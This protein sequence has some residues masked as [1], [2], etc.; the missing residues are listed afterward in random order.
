[1]VQVVQEQLN[2]LLSLP[3]KAIRSFYI[4]G[5]EVFLAMVLLD[6]SYT[7]KEEVCVWVT[8]CFEA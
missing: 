3:V 7:D 2:D 4:F 8:L 1:V 6:F 5:D